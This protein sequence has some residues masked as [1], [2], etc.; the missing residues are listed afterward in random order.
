MIG[1]FVCLVLNDLTAEFIIKAFK[2]EMMNI[3]LAPS[4]GLL[5]DR[6]YFKGYN[7]KKDIPMKLDL[8]ES[9]QKLADE[10]KRQKIHK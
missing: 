5:L 10:F 1:A 2:K 8:T 3:W 7:H 4:E 6:I 9:E